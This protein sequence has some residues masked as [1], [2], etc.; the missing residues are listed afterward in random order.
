MERRRF[1]RTGLEVAV[2]G[3]GCGAVGGL[4]T[5]GE[6]ADQERAVARALEYG[7][8]YFDTAAQYGDGASERNLGRVLKALRADV[9]VG[10]KVRVKPEERK[11]IDKAISQSLEASL[12]RMGRDSVDLFQLHNLIADNGD[13]KNLSAEIVLNE[14]VPA[15]ERLRKQGKTRFIGIT[16]LG[17]T[18]SLHRVVDAGVFDTAQVAYN[19]LN[20]SAGASLPPRYPAHDFDNLLAHTQAADIGTINIRVLAGGAL[21]GVEERHPL[22]AP[23]VEPIGSG[24]DYAMDAKRARQLEPLVKEGHAGSLIEAGLRFV[25]AHKGISTVLVGYSTFEHFEYAAKAMQ[26][27]PLTTPALQRLAELHAG[28]SGDTR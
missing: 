2:L 28:F 14:V 12:K 27:G 13:D 10:T 5:R 25:I 7:V 1:G 6:P 18:A 3:F 21:S 17:D 15:L 22:G 9:I 4:M 23:L 16:A 20:P 8:N 24:R 11:H 19:M 26:K